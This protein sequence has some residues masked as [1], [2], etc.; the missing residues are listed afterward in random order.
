MIIPPFPLLSSTDGL[1]LMSDARYAHRLH[2]D[3]GFSICKK[4]GLKVLIDEKDVTDR[5]FFFDRT[6]RMVGL[7]KRN[8]QGQF[9]TEIGPDGNIGI[10]QEWKQGEITLAK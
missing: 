5:C 10:A 8:E 1:P 7:Y 3:N 4:L 6:L 9:Y 2:P